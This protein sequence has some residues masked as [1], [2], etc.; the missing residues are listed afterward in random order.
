MNKKGSIRE[1]KTAR[2]RCGKEKS[3]EKKIE[4]KM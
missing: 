1:R 2:R 4:K 3:H